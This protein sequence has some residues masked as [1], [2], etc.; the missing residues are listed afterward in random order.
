MLFWSA[1]RVI[2]IRIEPGELFA[3]EEQK[4]ADEFFF[5]LPAQKK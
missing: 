3:K 5:M 2:Y 1:S 4:G